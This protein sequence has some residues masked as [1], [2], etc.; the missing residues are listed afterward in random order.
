M[1]ICL[2]HHMHMTVGSSKFV[3]IGMLLHVLSVLIRCFS[4]LAQRH[5]A[6]LLM[7]SQ[8]VE[9]ILALMHVCY[10]VSAIAGNRIWLITAVYACV[11][12]A[13]VFWYLYIYDVTD[14]VFML[15]YMHSLCEVLL[16]CC[17]AT[18]KTFENVVR[19]SHNTSTK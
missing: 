11:H 5:L 4:G 6:V 9:Y 16:S 15:A 17:V 18:A 19:M 14:C 7:L 3:P 10:C 2:H 12:C 13:G 1:L 8:Y